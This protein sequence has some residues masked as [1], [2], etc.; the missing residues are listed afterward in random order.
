M[1]TCIGV[2]FYNKETKKGIIC[3]ISPDCTFVMTYKVLE[4]LLEN[5][6]KEHSKWEYLI[7]DGFR[8]VDR[9]DTKRSEYIHSQIQKFAIK[10]PNINLK[11]F[12]Q[13]NKKLHA[14]TLSYEFAFDTL[15]GQFVTDEL[16]YN[17]LDHIKERRR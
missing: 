4:V 10:Y 3:H 6:S 2:L 1:D 9:K 14:G 11:S 5:S 13:V 8:N 15:S 7:V 16:F 17:P 12:E